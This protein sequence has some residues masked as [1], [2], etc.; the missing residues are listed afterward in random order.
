MKKYIIGAVLVSALRASAYYPIPAV[1]L[2]PGLAVPTAVS[3]ASELGSIVD[4]VPFLDLGLT[5][6]ERDKMYGVSLAALGSS[7][8][9]RMG[10]VQ[11][12]S[13]AAT[14]KGYSFGVQASFVTMADHGGGIQVGGVN[15]A[16]SC[17]RIQVGAV[18][19]ADQSYCIQVGAVNWANY[20]RGLQ[21]G[22]I[23]YADKQSK[24]LQAGGLSY[25]HKN[26]IWPILIWTW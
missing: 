15:I 3:S 2:A 20:S 25:N 17:M 21:I 24:M 14:A 10:G 7:Y 23:N 12:A 11:V 13:I 5:W 26:G 4:K 8:G 1:S 6:I 16:D 22:L 19:V 9:S 18:N